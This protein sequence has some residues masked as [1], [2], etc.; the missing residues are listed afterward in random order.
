MGVNLDVWQDSLNEE[1]KTM[2]VI[3]IREQTKKR[4]EQ[5]MRDE[6]HTSFDGLVKVLLTKSGYELRAEMTI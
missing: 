3:P 2:P 6:G 5:I 4:L 1:I